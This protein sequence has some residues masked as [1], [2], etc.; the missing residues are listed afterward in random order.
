M[1]QGMK[2]E[3]KSRTLTKAELNLMN[4]LWDKGQATVNELVDA[5]PEPKPAYTTVLTVMQVLTKKQVLRFEK[6]GKANVYIPLLSR[7]EYLNN[8]MDETRDSL[9]R[10]SAKSFLSFFARHEKISRREL[11]EILKEM[12]E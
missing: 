11:E 3:Q 2:E 5:L 4:I 6:Q 7:E 10:G 1:N 8:F 12:N 9:F